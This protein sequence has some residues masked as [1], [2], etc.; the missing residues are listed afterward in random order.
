MLIFE[1]SQPDRQA[2]SQGFAPINSPHLLPQTFQ[3][4]RPPK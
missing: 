1:Q 2:G 4:T 3:R